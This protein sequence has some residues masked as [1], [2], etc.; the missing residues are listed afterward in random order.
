[1]ILV[2][3]DDTD[4]PGTPGTNKLAMQ[5]AAD[6]MDR[7][8]CVRIV[9]HQLCADP[10]IPCTSQN[11]NA[12]LHL[13]PRVEPD[14]PALIERLRA[15][16]RSWY[17]PGS[18]PGLCIALT[19]PPQVTDFAKRA[20]REIVTQA[21]ARHLAIECG[22]HLEGLGGTEGGVIG[23]LA[24]V[25]LSQTGDDGRIVAMDIW[26][27]DVTGIIEIERL[28]QLGVIVRSLDGSI[29]P[30]SGRVDLVKKLRPNFRG[31]KAVLFVQPAQSPIADWTALK[32]N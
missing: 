14:P 22:M 27:G 26:P 18:D 24:A 2:G 20:Q 30:S 16:M 12:A 9:R 4:M 1:M 7:F 29:E 11:G 32:R 3:I 15:R 23:A 21:E 31:G 6:L 8:R 25:G 5:I 17:V 13:E 28:H 10:A 19:V